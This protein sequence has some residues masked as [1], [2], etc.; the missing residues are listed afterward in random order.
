MQCLTI[1]PRLQIRVYP[2][3]S[4][5][6]VEVDDTP[7]RAAFIHRLPSKISSIAWDP[8]DEVRMSSLRITCASLGHAVASYK[9]ALSCRQRLGRNVGGQGVLIRVT[10]DVLKNG[11]SAGH[12]DDW[13]L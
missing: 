2:L 3:A 7:V 13:G 9:A 12:C 6:A 11:L 10:P 4:V 8:F 1:T 5:R